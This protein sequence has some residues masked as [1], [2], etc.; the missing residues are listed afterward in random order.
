[1]IIVLDDNLLTCRILKKYI[2]SLIPDACVLLFTTIWDAGEFA[3]IN[4]DIT[5]AFVDIKLGGN[6]DPIS[7]YKEN[8]LNFILGVRTFEKESMIS[9]EDSIHII[10]IS[11]DLNMEQFAIEA[12]S[13]KFFCKPITKQILKTIFK[14]EI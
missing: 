7:Q 10:G 9:G 4:K 12:G 6:I 11:S 3:I 8:G 5:H 1:M 13:N 14:L 2:K